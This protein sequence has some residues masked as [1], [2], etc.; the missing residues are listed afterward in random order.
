MCLQKTTVGRDHAAVQQRG[1]RFGGRC[2]TGGHGP[3][4]SVLRRA[5]QPD[6]TFAD[7]ETVP[8][9]RGVLSDQF[10]FE[11]PPEPVGVHQP[12]VPDAGGRLF[13]RVGADT[14]QRGVP[15]DPDGRQRSVDDRRQ[16]EMVLQHR[17]S[18]RV[19]RLA[20]KL[21]DTKRPA[22]RRPS[23]IGAR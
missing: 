4:F 2:D 22:L 18:R 5:G 19:R 14:Q 15:T 16:T 10:V 23:F 11:K 8:P 7:A 12:A 13:R 9:A 1:H 21:F 3:F 17:G 6:G 20:R